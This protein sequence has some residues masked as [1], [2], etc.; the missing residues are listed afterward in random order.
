MGIIDKYLAKKKLEAE[1]LAKQA[2]IQAQAAGRYLGQQAQMAGQAIGSTAIQGL[3]KFQEYEKPIRE[4]IGQ[5]YQAT[6]TYGQ[7]MYRDAGN[8][9][10]SFKGWDKDKYGAVNQEV[11]QFKYQ[12]ALERKQQEEAERQRKLKQ[13][14][15]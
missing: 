15:P 5:A 6:K 9:V 14:Q 12:E 3:Q 11:E 10:D 7:E 8:F 2:Q 13:G 4:G 1:E